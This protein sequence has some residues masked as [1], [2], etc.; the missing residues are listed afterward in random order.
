MEKPLEVL[1]VLWENYEI[2]LGAVI[3]IA[4]VVPGEQPE[5]FL[6]SALNFLRKFSKK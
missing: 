2:L 4:L 3:A 5:K 1:K 6:Q